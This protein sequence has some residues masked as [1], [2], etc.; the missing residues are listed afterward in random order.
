MKA[1]MR[2][3]HLVARVSRG[4]DVFAPAKL[5]AIFSLIRSPRVMGMVKRP[6]EV[7]GHV[8]GALMI[9]R[10]IALQIQGTG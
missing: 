1:T 9:A 7:Q 3:V 2:R 4:L 5:L 6:Q 10:K 8:E